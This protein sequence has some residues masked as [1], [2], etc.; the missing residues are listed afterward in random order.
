MKALTEAEKQL[1][2]TVGWFRSRYGLMAGMDA[3]RIPDRRGLEEFAAAWIGTYLLD[4][5][6][7]YRSLVENGYLSL[8]DD[9][10]YSLTARGDAE[11]RA[12][13]ITNPFWLYEYDNFYAR[14]RT[15]RAHSIF[16]ER[17]YGKDLCQHGLADIFQLDRLLEFLNLSSNDRVL[18]AGCGNGLITE[19][20]HDRTSAFF[21]GIDIS[22]EA[23]R[24]ARLRTESKSARLVFSVGNMNRLDLSP[25]SFSAVIS[26]DTLYYVNE[27]EETLRQMLLLLREKGQLGLF[28]TQWTNDGEE[29]YRLAPDS[30]DLASLLKKHGLEFRTLDLTLHEAEHWRRKVQVLDELK[31]EFEK[32][33]SL[34]LYDYRYREAARYASWDLS[35]RSRYL[36]HVRL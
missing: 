3:G 28:Y 11:R 6:E 25:Q 7:A 12:L 22:E 15:S 24:Q 10:A 23:I 33:G 30:T 35:R 14:A 31:P 18:D 29:A 20:L 5:S 36:Y 2:I 4:W 9:G 17:V 8:A 19:Y 26:I 13:E 32:E 1:L 21:I 16:C 34:D 27:L